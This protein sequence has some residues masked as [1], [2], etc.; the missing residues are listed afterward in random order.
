[1][2]F[3]KFPVKKISTFLTYCM[4]MSL[5]LFS[6]AGCTTVPVEKTPRKLVPV[7]SIGILPAQVA[8]ITILPSDTRTREQLEAGTDIITTLLNDYF[9]NSQKAQMVSASALEGLSS[10]V[11]A[12]RLLT[13]AREAGQQLH[14][15]AVLIT[16]V[17]RYQ[18]REGSNYS[19]IR[20]ASVYFSLQLLDITSGQIIWSADFDQTQKTLF[21]NILPSTRSTG[22]GFRWLTAAELASAGLTKKLNS[23]PYL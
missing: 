2:N 9:K 6:A 16:S 12:A 22:S 11:A 7:N 10:S 5:L 21:E 1:M 14:Y 19:V 17:K 4:T 20:P 13:I 15:D 23:C 3:K 8:E 18:T